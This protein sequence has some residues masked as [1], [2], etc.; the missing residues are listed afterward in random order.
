MAHVAEWKKR[1]IKELNQLL[2]SYPVIGIVNISGIAAK[3]IQKMRKEFHGKIKIRATRN[4]LLKRAL[5]NSKNKELKKLANEVKGG[6]S[7]AL[8][9]INPFRLYK[10]FEKGK[11][12]APAKGKEMAP[13][14]VIIPKGNTGFP[15][16]PFVGELQK[17]GIP[18]VI[19]GGKIVVKKDHIVVKNGEIITPEIAEALGKLGIEPLEVGLNLVAAYENGFIF[20]ADDLKT[21]DK[22]LTNN[23][24][25]AYENAFNL[26]INTAI[27]TNDTINILLAKAFNDALNLSINAE[28]I[29]KETLPQILA[30]SYSEMLTIAGIVEGDALDEELKGAVGP[31]AITTSSPPPEE[32]SEDS[33]D[34][35]KKIKEEK[36]SEGDTLEGLGSLFGD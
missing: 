19:E 15:P 23:F 31:V 36:A 3:Q 22:E 14:D 28:I 24:A 2:K 6:A 17:I 32:K 10:L 18:A 20:K 9:E 16:G 7:L 25:R 26:A 34:G 29:N 1:E 4:T 21:D 5:A 27:P 11:T 35:E 30:K 8:T 12:S 33:A 13:N